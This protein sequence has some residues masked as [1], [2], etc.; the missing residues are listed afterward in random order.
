MEVWTEKGCLKEETDLLKE[1]DYRRGEIETIGGSIAAVNVKENDISFSFLITFSSF[2]SLHPL[3]PFSFLIL[4]FLFLLLFF[5]FC[6]SSSP[7]HLHIILFIFFF[8]FSPFSYLLFSFLYFI[9]FIFLSLFCLLL[10]FYCDWHKQ[11][12][13]VP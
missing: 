13:F 12:N 11:F 1:M 10:V 3:Y 7:P 5:S 8:F 6:S 2:S 4:L 9:F